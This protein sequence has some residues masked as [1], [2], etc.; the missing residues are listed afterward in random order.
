MLLGYETLRGG[1]SRPAARGLP[2]LQGQAAGSRMDRL[3]SDLAL[4]NIAKQLELSVHALPSEYTDADAFGGVQRSSP[5]LDVRLETMRSI[6]ERWPLVLPCL[7]PGR[8]GNGLGGHVVLMTGFVDSAA[9]TSFALL[10]PA[11]ADA[12]P[13]MLDYRRLLSLY[14]PHG[15]VVYSCWPYARRTRKAPPT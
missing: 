11:A 5:Q 7:V 14:A 13:L 8:G 2:G 4:R 9:S 3:A 15:G 10:D 1:R 12:N 6:L